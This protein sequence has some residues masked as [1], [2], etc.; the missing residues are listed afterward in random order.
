MYIINV[1]G[2]RK[3]YLLGVRKEYCAQP[4]WMGLITHCGGAQTLAARRRPWWCTNMAVHNLGCCVQ[5]RLCAHRLRSI[6]TNDTYSCSLYIIY[7]ISYVISYTYIFI[8]I[9]RYYVIY[10]TLL[11]L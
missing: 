10:K 4:S 3:E 11:S 7:N 9:Y 2:V 6:F 5:S 1:S 8:I